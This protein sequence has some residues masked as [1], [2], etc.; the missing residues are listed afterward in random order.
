MPEFITWGDKTIPRVDFL[1][2]LLAA[3]TPAR[4]SSPKPR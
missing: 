3:L 1:Q 2:S 4:V